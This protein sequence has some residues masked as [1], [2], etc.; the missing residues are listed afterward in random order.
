M[1]FAVA[2]TTLGPNTSA[3]RDRDLDRVPVHAVPGQRAPQHRVGGVDAVEGGVREHHA[4]AERV[5]RPVTLEHRDLAAGIAPLG[6]QRGQQPAGT[7]A[8]NGYPHVS[9]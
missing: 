2:V 8:E 6:Q 5:A 9:S 3:Y 1:N 4:E 7:A